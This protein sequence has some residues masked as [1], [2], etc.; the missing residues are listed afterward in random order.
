MILLDD[1][2]QTPPLG[3]L[4]AGL[5]IRSLLAACAFEAAHLAS[6]LSDLDATLAAAIA[7]SFPPPRAE[8]HGAA[9][10]AM[11]RGLQNADRARQEAEGLAALLNRLAATGDLDGTLPADAVTACL[12]LLTQRR[13]IIARATTP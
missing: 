1:D 10:N 5:P 6:A 12:P 13:R 3:D 9:P 2:E 8:G 4:P 7:A 11:L